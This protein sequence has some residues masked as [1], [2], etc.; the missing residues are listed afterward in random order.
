MNY[1][2]R[3]IKIEI[4]LNSK[5][6][7]WSLEREAFMKSSHKKIHARNKHERKFKPKKTF[8]SIGSEKNKKGKPRIR[9]LKWRKT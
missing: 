2:I 4:Y 6:L 9:K 7:L 3:L 5:T 8:L 1:S